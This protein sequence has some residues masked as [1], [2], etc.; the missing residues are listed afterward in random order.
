MNACLVVE[1]STDRPAPLKEE[2]RRELEAFAQR[3]VAAH[4]RGAGAKVSVH[5]IGEGMVLTDAD[6]LLR[7]QRKASQR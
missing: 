7:L 3:L 5:V 4:Y 1:V 2:T 6:A